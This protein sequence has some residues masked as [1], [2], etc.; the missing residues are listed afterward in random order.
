MYPQPG[1]LRFDACS[2][3]EEGWEMMASCISILLYEDVHV[4]LCETR[5]TQEMSSTSSCMEVASE[6]ED[7]NMAQPYPHCVVQVR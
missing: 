6:D 7:G 3:T 4:G 1:Q 5:I 2:E